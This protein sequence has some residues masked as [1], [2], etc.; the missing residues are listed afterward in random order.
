VLQLTLQGTSDCELATT[1]KPE[2]ARG[3]L[4]LTGYYKRFVKGYG[5]IYK[6]LTL[7]LRKDARGWNEEASRAFNYLKDLM[8]S[9]PVLALSDF[10]KL[11]VMETIWLI[12]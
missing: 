12:K 10:N 7:L 6:P 9:T 8:T 4:G 1:S 5:N 2:T 3:F 11:F